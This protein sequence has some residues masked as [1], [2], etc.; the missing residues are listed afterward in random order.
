MSI[1]KSLKNLR[2]SDYYSSLLH[3]SGFN[4]KS[5][6]NNPVFNG[7][8]QST[9]ISLSSK[10]ERVNFSNYI[11]PSSNTLSDWIDTFY[12]INSIILTATNDNPSNRIANTKWVLDGGGRFLVGVG[13]DEK[14]F[15]PG[16]DGFGSGD[17]AGEYTVKLNKNHLPSHTHN[18]NVKTSVVGDSFLTNIFSFY[19][20]PTVNPR[21][22][23]EERLYSSEASELIPNV[24]ENPFSYFLNQDE[25]EAFQNNSTFDNQ[26]NYRDYIIKKR[27]EEGF[28]YTD[29]DFDP[30]LANYSLA[31]WG[32]T[33]VFGPGWG[34]LVNTADPNTKIFIADSPRPVGVAWNNTD[35]VLEKADYDFRDSDRVHPGRFSSEDLIKARNIIIEVLGKDEA[36]IALKDVNRLKEL[37]ELTEDAITSN[38]YLNTQVRGNSTRSSKN[39]GIGVE[40]NNIP[41]NYGLYVWR[42]VPLDFKEPR[43]PPGGGTEEKPETEIFQGTITTNK[44]ALN[45]EEWARDRGWDGQSFGIITIAED[46]YIYSDEIGVPALTTGEWPSGLTIFNRGF[47]MGRGGDGGSFASGKY[48]NLSWSLGSPP[49]KNRYDG[50]DGSDAI[51]VN[52]KSRVSIDNARGAIAG[53]GGGGAGGGTGNFGGGGGGAGGGKGGIGSYPNFNALPGDLNAWEAGGEGGIPGAP[54]SDGGNSKNIE[55][56]ISSGLRGSSTK[57]FLQGRGGEAGGGGAGGY[58]RG[59]NDPHG[60]G[61]G[62][63]RVLTPTASGGDGGDI[64][65]GSGGSGTN[66]GETVSSRDPRPWGNAAG[67]GGWAADGG[68]C[69]TPPDRV[70]EDPPK[71][72]KG[73]KAVLSVEGSNYS[74]NGGIIY[75]VL[76]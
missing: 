28:R 40:H 64:G 17:L 54:G 3:L 5:I 15:T 65:G 56:G 34:G 72:G 10:G 39:T 13:G 67:G 69:T 49:G 7:I 44:E 20:G 9:G 32:G 75:G 12:P 23:T 42:R 2:I 33:V 47:I 22:L 63:G 51:Y 37:D 58:R 27:H 43:V 36:E 61:G 73:G 62:G 46:V 57:V 18:V 11:A 24:S 74:V 30:K 68:D 45:L 35:I 26:E 8:G 4:V 53:G 16:S 70:D 14:T 38:V 48:S 60:G 59:G 50:W 52:T 76:E 66:D 6:D 31:G 19:F 29:A 55:G 21:G 1:G 71:G 41:P 25:I